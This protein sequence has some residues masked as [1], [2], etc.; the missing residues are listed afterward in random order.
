MPAT[1]RPYIASHNAPAPRSRLRDAHALSIATPAA[2]GAAARLPDGRRRAAADV[3]A[4]GQERA[5]ARLGQGMDGAM[6]LVFALAC[7][8]MVANLYYAQA[9]I[10]LIGPALRLPDS[11]AGLTVTVTQLGYGAGLLLLASLG[12]L[13]ENRRL[14]LLTVGGT[15]LG[16]A[17]IAV[18]GSAAG[19]LAASFV[20]GF[21]AVGAQVLIPLAAHLAEER[22][23]GR[24]IGNIMGGL[25]GGIMLARPA[26]NMAAAGFGWRAI[27]WFSAGLMLVIL[28]MLWRILPRRS[29]R[30]GL[31]YG[32]ILVSTLHLLAR[33]RVLQRRAAYQGLVFAMFNLFWT[34]VPLLLAGRFG[35]DQRG[36]ALFALAGAGGALAAP[37]AG[38]LA[39]RGLVWQATGLALLGLL[40]GFL[41]AGWMAAA[42]WLL[43]LAVVAVLLD[44]ATQTNQVAGQRVIYSL[45]AEA[46]SRLNAGYMT[47]VFLCGAAGSW[48]GA[49]TFTHGGWW[50]TVLT[51][52]GLA[53]MALLIFATERRPR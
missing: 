7:G 42:G 47:V 14:I 45:A 33:Q 28:A 36:I 25:I 53:V 19:F 37:L 32:Q 41:A 38:R 6:V 39:D 5:E 31:H 11:L 44:A 51:G 29:P 43:G 2:T 10:G 46:R 50:A 18:S 21:C 8:A 49:F 34:A 13:V 52:A 3:T 27:F 12:D 23:R 30:S 24:V 48:L 1:G 15:G 26:A 4:S 9:L 40:L 35:L 17:G 20:V 22:N 16:L